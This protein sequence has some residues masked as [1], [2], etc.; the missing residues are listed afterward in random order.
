MKTLSIW[1]TLL[2]SV[3]MLAMGAAFTACSDS[4]EEDPTGTP[5]M[6]LSATSLAFKNVPEG[7][8]SFNIQMTGAGRWAITGDVNSFAQLSPLSGTKSAKVTVLPSETA[9]DRTLTLTVTLYMSMYGV[10]AE[11]SKSVVTVHQTAG[12]EAPEAAKLSDVLAL[13][14][15][16]TIPTGTIIEA[17]VVSNADLNNLTSKKGCYIQDATGGLQ[18]YLSS[19]HSFK[20]GEKVTVDLSGATKSAYNGAVQVQLANDK[21]TSKGVVEAPEAKV[22]S[23]EDFFANKYEG[24]YIAIENVQIAESDLAKTFVMD[25]RHTSINAQTKDGKVFVIF[26][27]SYSSY[28]TTTVP[29]GAGT[30]KGIGSIN[31]GNL[32]LIFGQ[33]SDFA[34][35]TGERF[36]VEASAATIDKITTAGAYEVKDAVVA[37]TYARGFLME[38]ATGEILVYQGSAPTVTVGDKVDVS[39]TVSAYGGLLQFGGSD[40]AV[41]KTGTATP[42]ARTAVELDGAGLDNLLKNIKI[43]YVKYKG[44]LVIEGNYYNIEVAGTSNRGAVQYPADDMKT[45]LDAL[46]GHVV[47]VEGFAIGTAAS[48]TILSTMA[49]KVSDTGEE[50]VGPGPSDADITIDFTAQNYANEQEV[51]TLTQ[52]GITLTFDAGGNS[53]GTKF[54]T[55]GN[56][57][58]MYAQNTMKVAG[59]TMTKIELVFA[60]TDKTGTPANDNEITT[61]KATYA[62]PAWTGE[63]DEVTF[64]IAATRSNGSTG[65]HR[66]LTKVLI[67]LKEGGSVKPAEPTISAASSLSF[68][69]TGGDKELSYTAANLGENNVYAKIEGADAAQFSVTAPANGK[70][71]VTAAVNE[72]EAAKNATLVLYVAAS[73]GGA[74]VAS[75]NVA[76]SQTGKSSQGG[77]DAKTL[78]ISRSTIDT[79]AWTVNGYGS[80]NTSNLDTYMKWTISGID[81][82]GAKLCLPT[83]GKEYDKVNAFQGQGNASDGAKT[84]RLGNTVSMGK[85]KKITVVS[86]GTTYT[87]NFNLTVGTEQIVGTTIPS[88]M[89]G[90]ANM[91]QSVEELSDPA[92]KKYTNVYVPTT[93]AGFFAIYKNTSGAL[94]FSEIIVEYE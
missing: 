40:L 19:N 74:A 22:V 56:A 46:K 80:Q 5:T 64:T 70:V 23:T 50:P 3:M 2:C 89:V 45:A 67:T 83:A 14:E 9:T 32:Q 1:K 30:I 15:G 38:D 42:K 76:L 34:D 29:Q 65:G 82:I 78:T 58:R 88:S 75:T 27:S 12:G 62:E 81:F 43:E 94:Y 37:A 90:A 28:G 71:T 33:N 60:S 7:E 4:D 6:E 39:G 53:N 92:L 35:L 16:A 93:D 84:C 85:I 10:E 54:Y 79:S 13:A 26:S 69:A 8:Q 25:G 63:A 49:V 44:T 31:N 41:A 17:V 87:P 59:A 72:T 18:L 51:S 68:V 86:Y 52:D 77:D 73:E 21:I 61:D 24:Q 48:N 55:S 91:E 36:S 57:L 11:V 66:R 47:E 20:F